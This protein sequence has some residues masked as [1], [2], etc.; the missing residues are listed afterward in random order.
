MRPE[1]KQHQMGSKQFKRFGSVVS[2][3]VH[4]GAWC[5]GAGGMPLIL[6]SVKESQPL[7]QEKRI[8]ECMSLEG[9]CEH[10]WKDKPQAQ[11]RDSE[12]VVQDIVLCDSEHLQ[13]RAKK[14]SGQPLPVLDHLYHRT[15]FLL[16]EG[17]FLYFS[18][19]LLLLLHS[20]RLLPHSYQVFTHV[21]ISG[22]PAQE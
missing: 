21:K 2:V 13:A 1:S 3:A 22:S 4:P 20:L 15:G 11:S 19:C 12:C 7:V 14:L 18:L 5:D 10:C 9:T 16:L 8:T 17:H 6:M